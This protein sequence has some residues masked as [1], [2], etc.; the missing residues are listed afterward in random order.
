MLIACY[1][2][3]LLIKN[4]ILIL[5][6]HTQRSE[7]NLGK[8]VPSSQHI[9]HREETQVSRLGSKCLSWLS[10]LTSPKFITVIHPQF[11]SLSPFPF[12]NI[13][14]ELAYPTSSCRYTGCTRENSFVSSDVQMVSGQ[15][16]AEGLAPWRV[17]Y[18]KAFILFTVVTLRGGAG[19]A[20][21]WPYS[22]EA[23]T[24]DLG[25]AACLPWCALQN[26]AQSVHTLGF[27]S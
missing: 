27:W 13:Q 18:H 2:V 26:F 19:R 12:Y 17:P 5:F 15:V 3:V 11:T 21:V 20:E 10:P 24:S 14:R 1:C 7:G 23:N 4:F 22:R 16:G 25:R 9:G 8:S 6:A